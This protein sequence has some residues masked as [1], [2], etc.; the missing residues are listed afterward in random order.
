MPVK[1]YFFETVLRFSLIASSFVACLVCF[2][3]HFLTLYKSC[4]FVL[5][6]S[7]NAVPTVIQY[8]KSLVL[9]LF[10]I[11]KVATL[12]CQVYPFWYF[13]SLPAY[14]LLIY[15]Y[16]MLPLTYPFFTKHIPLVFWVPIGTRLEL[17]QKLNISSFHRN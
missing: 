10:T 4:N 17:K 5:Q 15:V 8:D 12:I 1:H 7:T 13:F 2:N 6:F 9:L 16:N 14:R 3:V 11:T